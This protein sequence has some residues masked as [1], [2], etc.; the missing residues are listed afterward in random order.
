[1]PRLPATEWA[2]GKFKNPCWLGNLM[3]AKKAGVSLVEA[4]ASRI[5]VDTKIGR[6]IIEADGVQFHRAGRGRGRVLL[7]PE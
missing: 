6:V 7:G 4:S 2:V 1:M 5:V 3:A